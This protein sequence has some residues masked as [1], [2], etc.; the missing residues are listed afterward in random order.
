MAK[1]RKPI[2]A[3][4]NGTTIRVDGYFDLQSCKMKP[5]SQNFID[6]LVERL[7]TWADTTEDALVFEEFFMLTKINSSDY[8][9]WLPK[10][11]NL[12]MAHD[13]AKQVIGI[14]REKGGLKRKLDPGMIASSMPMYSKSWKEL[15]EWR[16]KLKEESQNQGNN[17]TVVLEKIPDS[18]LVPEKK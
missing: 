13:Y 7:I 17:I 11:E 6:L 3:N 8:Y 2:I 4:A 12:K 1:A 9:G 18:K 15:A 16:A 5:I 14:R 10:H